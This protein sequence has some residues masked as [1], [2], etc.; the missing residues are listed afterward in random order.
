[1]AIDG[2]GLGSALVALPAVLQNG[3]SSSVGG[4]DLV[5]QRTG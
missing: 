5:C 3:P 1:M 2:P 4:P